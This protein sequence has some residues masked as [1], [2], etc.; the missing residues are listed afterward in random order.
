MPYS[1]PLRGR[2][3]LVVTSYLIQNPAFA[4]LFGRLFYY[5]AEMSLIRRMLIRCNARDELPLGGGQVR[6]SHWHCFTRE[7][8]GSR[9]AAVVRTRARWSDC[10]EIGACAKERGMFGA[11]ENRGKGG[12]EACLPIVASWCVSLLAFALA[13]LFP[14][15]PTCAWTLEKAKCTRVS[16]KDKEWKRSSMSGRW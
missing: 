13:R 15:M 1:P 12:V 2:A 10:C 11:W 16:V 7:V 9:V 5:F 8:L 4:I 14:S 6:L 3:P